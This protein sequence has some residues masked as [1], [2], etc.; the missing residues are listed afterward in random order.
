MVIRI[1]IALFIS[2]SAIASSTQEVISDEVDLA[3]I[4]M[5]KGT[6]SNTQSSQC[7]ASPISPTL[8]LTAAHCLF[9]DQD[10]VFDELEFYPNYNSPTDVKSKINVVNILYYKLSSEAQALKYDI[11][12]LTLETPVDKYFEIST[13]PTLQ[14]EV[15]IIGYPLTES[16]QHVWIS[17]CD[18]QSNRSDILIYNCPTAPGMSGAPI[19]QNI[20]GTL[21][22][23]GIHLG[24]D[25]ENDHGLGLSN[26]IVILNNLIK[27]SS[28]L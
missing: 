27:V 16:E 20:N 11:A 22:I 6:S 12:I 5:L 15:S 25:F 21:S 24:K 4:G 19:L 10:N 28:V 17:T 8:I 9:D 1:L 26:L 14:G 2:F 3:N 18:I 13:A 7:T 23:V